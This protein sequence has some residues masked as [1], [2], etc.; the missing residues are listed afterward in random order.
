[1]PPSRF[2]H[3]GSTGPTPDPNNILDSLS[4][5]DIT[6]LVSNWLLVISDTLIADE[7]MIIQDLQNFAIEDTQ[8]EAQRGRNQKT[9]DKCFRAKLG[10]QAEKYFCHFRTCFL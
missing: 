3:Q 4:Y 9:W 5:V 8:V 1:M 7:T 10:R 2:Y 6:G